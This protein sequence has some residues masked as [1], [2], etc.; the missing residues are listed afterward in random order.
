MFLSKSLLFVDVI[1]VALKR[2]TS[3]VM[4]CK[5]HSIL[6]DV[7]PM[8]IADAKTS[9]MLDPLDKIFNLFKYITKNKL[10]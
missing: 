5:V 1:V 6:V 4:F 7:D 3:V 8:T 10:T 2:I 9:G